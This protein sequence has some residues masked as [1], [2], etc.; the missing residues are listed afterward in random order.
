MKI[1]GFIVVLLLI[2]LTYTYGKGLKAPYFEL[3]DENGNIVKLSDLKGYVSLI[4][5]CKTTCKVCKKYIPYDVLYVYKKYKDKG[6]KTLIMV[7]DTVSPQKVKKMKRELGIE[8]IPCIF[9]NEDILRKYRILG[10]P[11]TYLLDKDLSIRR[12]FLGRHSYKVLE[13]WIKRFLK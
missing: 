8:E 6:F 1:K 10:S 13:E 9:A 3:K 7:M 11:T 12:I 5:F 2:T 4:V